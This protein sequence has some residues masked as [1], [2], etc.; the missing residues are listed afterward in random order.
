MGSVGHR[1]V[2]YVHQNEV[3]TRP[4]NLNEDARL[5]ARWGSGSKGQFIRAMS[6]IYPKEAGNNEALFAIGIYNSIYNVDSACVVL[7]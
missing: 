2:L 1:W 6:S 7:L 3:A 5:P 4:A